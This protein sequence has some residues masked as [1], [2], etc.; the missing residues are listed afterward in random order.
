MKQLHLL[1]YFLVGFLFFIL[2]LERAFS[3]D[4]QFHIFELECA[5]PALF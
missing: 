2:S 1:R 4:Q 5:G 3:A